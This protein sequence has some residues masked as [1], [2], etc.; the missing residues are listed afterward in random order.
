MAI[1][2]SDKQLNAWL[3]RRAGRA[4]ARME[5]VGLREEL[6]PLAG[7]QFVH[8]GAVFGASDPFADC[9]EFLQRARVVSS[10]A[11]GVQANSP[12]VLGSAEELPFQSDSVNALVL[13]HS[14]ELADDPHKVI[15]EA[16]RVLAPEGHLVLSG[17]NPWGLAGIAKLM[18][19]RRAPPWD[20]RWL[21]AGR[22]RDWMALLGFQPVSARQSWLRKTGRVL[23]Y[24]EDDAHLFS[25]QSVGSFAAGVYVLAA[26]KKV[27]WMRPIVSRWRV[28]RRLSAVGLAETS[29]QASRDR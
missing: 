16:H 10:T 3:Q 1:S 13:P 2:T 11:D 18:M 4:L 24:S 22:V 28:R 5:L 9:G 20:R 17:F 7:R 15:R 27:I 19:P 12:A 29:S 6:S 25:G 14:L 8:V 21:G 23:G 26:R